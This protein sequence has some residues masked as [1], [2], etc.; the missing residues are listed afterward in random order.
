[1][2]KRTISMAQKSIVD[3]VTAFADI[4]RQHFTVQKIILF[5]SQARGTARQDSDIDVAVVF[6]SLDNDYLETAAR[7]FQLRRN[8]DSRIEPAIFE[9]NHDPSGFLE[10]IMKTGTLIFSNDR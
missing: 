1:M 7:L 5:G 2:N 3:I 4:V 10:D 8:I 9:E 6:K